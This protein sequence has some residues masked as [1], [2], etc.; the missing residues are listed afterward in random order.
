MG[1]TEAEALDSR[2][3]PSAGAMIKAGRGMDVRDRET[4][5]G[6][7][8]VEDC[9]PSGLARLLVCDSSHCRA[10]KPAA[11]VGAAPRVTSSFCTSAANLETTDP[12]PKRQDRQLLSTRPDPRDRQPGSPY[13][14]R[15]G[16][17]TIL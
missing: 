3:C 16:A 10:P 6:R 2:R 14:H 11:R 13:P 8:D 17:Y 9:H 4:G 7:F 5:T 15:R 12:A 1:K